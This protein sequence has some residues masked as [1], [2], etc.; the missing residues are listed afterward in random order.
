MAT[1]KKATKATTKASPLRIGASVIVRTVTH[2][3]TGRIV[4]LSADEI[5]LDDAAWVAD[6]D[7]WSAA[8]TTG[9][10]SEVE[11]YPDPVSLAR[12]AIV[13]VTEWRHDLPRTVK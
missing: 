9:T 10:L 2:Y 3:Y 6:T 8:L 11:P 12:G 13:D 5:V 1:T 7:R 4:A